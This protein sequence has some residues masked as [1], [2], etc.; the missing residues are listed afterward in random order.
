MRKVIATVFNHS[1]DGLIADPGTD[2][3][4]FCFSFRSTNQP[5]DPAHL[6][7]LRTA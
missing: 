6:E 7:F 1:L 3:W 2:F 5:D 4:S